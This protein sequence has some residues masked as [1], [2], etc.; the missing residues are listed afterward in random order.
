MG[1]VVEIYA[2]PYLS[3][4]CWIFVPRRRGSLTSPKRGGRGWKKQ[5]ATSSKKRENKK[6]TCWASEV[7]SHQ[8][9]AGEQITACTWRWS[10]E[11]VWKES[12]RSLV[13]R[14]WH[15]GMSCCCCFSGDVPVFSRKCIDCN[16]F[17]SLDLT[18]KNFSLYPPRSFICP[19]LHRICSHCVCVCVFFANHYYYFLPL[20]FST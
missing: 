1:K 19:F 14:P 12:S 9:P 10:G 6:K 2:R 3:G 11:S 4:I 17:I 20:C 16:S 15:V 7:V 18:A 5:A 13:E 8:A